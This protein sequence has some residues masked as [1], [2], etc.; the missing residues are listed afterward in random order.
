MA[1]ELCCQAA[2]LTAAEYRWLRLLGEFD[3]AGGWAAAG[4][5]SCAA[6]LSWAC[7]VTAPAARERVRVA[8]AL[9]ALPLVCASFGAGRLSHS[10]VR[11]ITR[12]ASPENEQ[13]LVTYGESA[14]AAQLE[15]VVRG[16][17]RVRRA[18]DGRDAAEQHENRYV[19]HRIDEEGF[20]RIDAR[21]WDGTPPDYSLAVGL[22]LDVSAETPASVAG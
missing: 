19:R 18:Q 2:H 20:V 17:R 14:T 5:R 10:K 21:L 13:L 11:A 4:A 22:L 15:T 12:I 3:E 8:R 1:D 6:W 9:P 7:G 16:F